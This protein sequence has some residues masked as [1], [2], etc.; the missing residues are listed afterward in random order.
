MK[1]THRQKTAQRIAYEQQVYAALFRCVIGY[2]AAAA[3]FTLAGL[4][5]GLMLAPALCFGLVGLL[6]TKVAV[7]TA[8]LVVEALRS[9]LT[10]RLEIAPVLSTGGAYA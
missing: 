1:N 9:G 2:S 8:F 5:L 7:E 10:I 6:C 4:G 3:A